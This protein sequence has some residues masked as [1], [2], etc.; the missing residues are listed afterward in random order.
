M[1]LMRWGVVW[2][3]V[4]IHF[5]DMQHVE[6]ALIMDGELGG[7]FLYFYGSFSQAA[8]SVGTWQGEVVSDARPIPK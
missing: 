7:R 8:T 2:F 1:S 3:Q 5:E 4:V 6:G